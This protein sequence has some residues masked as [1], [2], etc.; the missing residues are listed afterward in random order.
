[1][2]DQLT[3]LERNARAR[4]QFIEWFDK[5]KDDPAFGA[6][7]KMRIAVLRQIAEGK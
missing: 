4:V 1:M 2:T 5:Y 7:V 6:L 3:L